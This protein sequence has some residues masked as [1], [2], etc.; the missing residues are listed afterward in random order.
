MV[1]WFVFAA[2]A[3]VAI[4]VSAQK[5]SL[6]LEPLEEYG[7][8][9]LPPPFN[10]ESPPGHNSFGPL[11]SVQ[12]NVN[13]NG[14][15]IIGDAANEPS[16][17]VD[18]TNHARMAVGWRQFNNVASNFRQA[19]YAYTTNAGASWTFPGV[20]QNNVFRSDPVLGGDGGSSFYYLSLL[21][22]FYDDLWKSTNFGQT[23]TNLGPATGGDKQWFASDL[24]NST[25]HG[26]LY[27]I[28]ST[29]GNNYGGRQFSRSTN[30]GAT[31]MNP[32]NIPDRP[33]WG[34]VDIGPN[35]EVYICGTDG[36]LPSLRFVRSSNAK[37]SAIT[38]TFDLS[39]FVDMGGD[40]TY[41]L[42]INPGGLGGQ[43]WIA[44][45][46]GLGPARGNIYMLCS[47]SG[48]ASN[49]LDVKLRRSTD[50]GAS[51]GPVKRVN[52]DPAN[53]GKYHWFGTLSVAPSGR[54]DVVWNDTR[55]SPGN[56]ESALYYAYSLDAGQT[57]SANQQV[58]NMFNQSLGYPNQNKMGDYI[59]MI[60]DNAGADVAYC[61]TF[62]LEQDV[63]YL[64][65]PAPTLPISGRVTLGD[66]TGPVAGRTV[67]IEIRNS[68]TGALLETRNVVLDG[69]GNYS[70]STSA[71]I[72]GSY[73]VTAKASHWLR[74]RRTPVAVGFSG[75]S[76]V[77][78]VLV[79]GDIDGDNENGIGDYARLSSAYNSAP[80][81]GNWDPEADLNGDDGVDIADYAILSI[82]YGLNG[83]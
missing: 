8:P 37:N 79:N 40:I 43:V 25:G 19:G 80:G 57:F 36:N 14:N 27:Q 59:G 55:L 3:V 30:G 64:R 6:L 34:T 74:K 21:E 16:I 39:V 48:D 38:P 73:H 11:S 69:S 42:P 1:R 28:W 66:W 20:L 58:S 17:W 24:T 62:N 13:A 18:P 70:F 5:K 31:W 60:S 61:A 4:P 83:D 10:L 77:D 52:D 78:F 22:T 2:L 63:Y 68:V 65:I 53:Q 67:T 76:G 54:L 23:Y 9:P 33:V 26:F 44:C 29:A 35:G 56:T 32:I 71:I 47:I 45:D 51:W 41:G 72:T 81:D 7:D 12:T 75:A 46:R 49:P 15:N 50:G 82:N